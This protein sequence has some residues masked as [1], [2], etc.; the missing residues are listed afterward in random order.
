MPD[1]VVR[2]G[3]RS[4]AAALFE[5]IRRIYD[6]VF[7]EPPYIWDDKESERHRERLSRLM[8]DPTFG[9]A[10][11]QDG[12]GLVGFAYGRT[13]PADNPRLVDFLDPLPPGMADEWEGRTFILV[14]L[15]VPKQFRGQ[16]IGRRL[17]ETLVASRA[18]ERAILGVEPEATESQAFYAHLGWQKIGRRREVGYHVPFYVVYLLPL[19]LPRWPAGPGASHFSTA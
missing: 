17:V 11:A 4:T 9:L 18:E 12:P 16:R 19:R 15:A 7:S 10:V 14:D 8:A 6:E 3:D 2:I 5:H 1:I 13:V